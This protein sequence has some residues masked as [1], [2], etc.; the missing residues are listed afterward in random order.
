MKYRWS[1]VSIAAMG[2][3]AGA[4]SARAEGVLRV[5]SDPAYLPYSD[6]AGQ[7]F[8]NA[9][10]EVV[11]HALGDKL[12]Y[13]WYDTRAKGGFSQF[14]AN[15]LDKGKC[16]V[17]MSLPFGTQEEQTTNPWYVSS[18]VFIYKKA[19]SYAITSLDSPILHQLKIGFE[20]ETPIETGL[21]LRGMVQTA[22]PFDVAGTPGESPRT[23]LQ[24]VQ[25][26]KVD[27]MITWEPAIGAY[28][29]DYPDLKIVMVPNERDMGPPEQYTFPMA[30]G[31][32]EGNN[33]LMH[34]LNAV[35]KAHQR[36]LTS[37]LE[38]HGVHYPGS[39]SGNPSP[40]MTGTP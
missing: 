23:M 26:G 25:D 7:G 20:S 40:Q 13:V 27:V 5:C 30:M 33:A 21:Q 37:V 38:Q 8:E 18:Y 36:Q 31:V 39:A 4:L 35:I 1:L 11:A 15:T 34:K 17:V 6:T 14:L 19:K 2:L 10:A 32:R 22:I 24:A 3:L 16:D 12:E 9:A 29:K 28:L